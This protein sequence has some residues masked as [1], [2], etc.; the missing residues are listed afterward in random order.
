MFTAGGVL[1][2]VL[3]TKMLFGMI[4]C[5]DTVSGHWKKVEARQNGN[6]VS[7]FRNTSNV[8]NMVTTGSK[9]PRWQR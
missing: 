3:Q 6:T 9:K 2:T 7:R 8:P 5:C 1:S 4:F